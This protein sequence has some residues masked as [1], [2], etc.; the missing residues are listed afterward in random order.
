MKVISKQ[1]FTYKAS[2]DQHQIKIKWK[3]LMLVIVEWI[4]LNKE[5]L[6]DPWWDAASPPPSPYIFSQPTFCSA[7]HLS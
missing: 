3:W 7:A 5:T 4:P 6:N 1:Y 2:T